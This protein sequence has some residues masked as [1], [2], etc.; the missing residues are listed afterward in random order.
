MLISRVAQDPAERADQARPVLVADVEHVRPEPGLDR[1][2]AD[3]DQ[4]RLGILEQGAADRARAALG[5]HLDGEQGL[6]V[7][8][9]LAGDH[10]DV[11]VALLGQCRGVDHVDAGEQ[12]PQQ[13]G[14]HD[15]GQRPGVE[16]GRMAGIAD[17][18]RAQTRLR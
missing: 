13:A 9:R 6:V 12:R 1:D 11:D 2:A 15:L 17:R 5:D 4:A 7:V 18:D 8:D 16:R 14:Q 3:R 10:P